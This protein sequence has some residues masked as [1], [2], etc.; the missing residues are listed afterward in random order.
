[1]RRLAKLK[2]PKAKKRVHRVEVVKLQEAIEV[3]EKKLN[4]RAWI[5]E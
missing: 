4:S 5:E 1:M 2:N 3:I